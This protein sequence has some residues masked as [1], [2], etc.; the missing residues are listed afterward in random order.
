MSMVLQKATVP[1]KCSFQLS[2]QVLKYYVA[3]SEMPFRTLP[4]TRSDGWVYIMEPKAVH[5]N[6][7]TGDL[8]YE[9]FFDKFEARGINFRDARL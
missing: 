4:Y 3:F 1:P 7:D 2:R 8:T 6:D 9:F 5:N